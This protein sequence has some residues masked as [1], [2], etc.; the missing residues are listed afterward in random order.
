M[1]TCAGCRVR[2]LECDTTSPCTECEKAG[3][4]CVRLNVRFRNLVC[5]GIAG[6]DSSKYDF[7][8]DGEQPWVD[9]ERKLEFVVDTDG[10]TGAE[11]LF[12][13]GQGAPSMHHLTPDPTVHLS[14]PND[15]PPEYTTIVDHDTPLDNHSLGEEP[16]IPAYSLMGNGEKSI[17][18]TSRTSPES[19][20]PTKELGWPLKSLRDGKLL[21]H[22][23]THLAPWVGTKVFALYLLC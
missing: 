17:V 18:A 7:F 22:F 20:A 2:H 16:D 14:I 1:T 9:I 13:D 19:M 11:T 23:I 4:E 8:F 5:P 10:E 3:R 6:V 15:D 21:Q 12:M